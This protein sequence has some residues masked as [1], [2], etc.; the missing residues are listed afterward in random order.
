MQNDADIKKNVEAQLSWEPGLKDDDIAVAVRDGVVTLAGFVKSYADFYAAESAAKKVKGVKAVANDIEVRLPQVDR[1]PDPDIAR[2]AV[3]ALKRDLP[4]ASERIK[5]VV[6]DGYLSLQGEVE[7]KYQKDWAERAV[8]NIKGV[9]AVSNIIRIKPKVEPIELKKKIE[10]AFVRSAQ[11][12]AHHV[13]VEADGSQVTL[14]G[15]V[16]S[17]AERQEAERQAWSAP[18]VTEVRN[19]LTIDPWPFASQAA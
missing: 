7:W 9:V 5:V 4:A 14:K 18:G 2:D 10:E 11:V 3:D 8:R 16:R 15:H 12:D 1:R 17:W 19:E 6:K 13:V